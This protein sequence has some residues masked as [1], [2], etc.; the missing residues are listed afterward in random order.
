MQKVPDGILQTDT[1]AAH[2]E[3]RLG[4]GPQDIIFARQQRRPIL[5]GGRNDSFPVAVGADN[6]PAHFLATAILLESVDFELRSRDAL[7]TGC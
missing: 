6:N 1:I 7:Q 4:L 2:D 3:E 5:G